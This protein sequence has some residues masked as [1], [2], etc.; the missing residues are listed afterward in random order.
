SRSIVEAHGGQ[1]WAT[2]NIPKGALFQF[3]LPTYDHSVRTM[4]V[5]DS[6]RIAAKIELSVKPFYLSGQVH[7]ERDADKVK[8]TTVSQIFNLSQNAYCLIIEIPAAIGR[9][10]HRRYQSM[11]AVNDN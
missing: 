5:L 6:L 9:I 10:H 1:L 11:F 3:T 2:A 7:N 4:R 8:P